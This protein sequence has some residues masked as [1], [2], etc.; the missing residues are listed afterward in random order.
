MSKRREQ[1]FIQELVS[2]PPVEA[3]DKSV[4]DRLARRK[5]MPIKLGPV[6]SLQDRVAGEL[7]AVEPLCIDALWKVRRHRHSRECQVRF[8]VVIA[9]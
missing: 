6:R 9:S 7:V 8:G 2:Q 4:L 1:S 3:F 5:V